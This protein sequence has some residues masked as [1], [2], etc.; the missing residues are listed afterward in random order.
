MH[1]KRLSTTAI[2]TAIDL[3]PC[4]CIRCTLVVWHLIVSLVLSTFLIVPF[5]ALNF[6]E[7]FCLSPKLGWPFG[8]LTYIEGS[9][10]M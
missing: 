6:V 2:A 9:Y 5:L 3:M 10:P 8:A 7:T 1:I 4:I